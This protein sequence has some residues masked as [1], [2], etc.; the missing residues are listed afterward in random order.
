MKYLKLLTILTLLLP[1]FTYADFQVNLKYGAKG[2]EVRELQ[3]FL[4]SEGHL[5]GTATGNFYSLTLKAVKEF[6]RVNNLP[7]TGYFGSMSRAIANQILAIDADN[8]ELQELGSITAPV[9]TTLDKKIEDLN[10]KIEQQNAIIQEQKQTQ[11]QTNVILEQ[12]KSNTN[13]MPEPTIQKTETQKEVVKELSIY[14]YYVDSSN[15][16]YQYVPLTDGGTA[17]VQKT[18][19]TASIYLIVDYKVDGVRPKTFKSWKFSFTPDDM[20]VYGVAGKNTE[21][22][23]IKN[24]FKTNE[25]GDVSKNLDYSWTFSPRTPN[26]Y[27]L[28]FEVDGV[29]KEFKVNVTE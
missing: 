1:V 16:G 26:I 10:K 28:L 5:T 11:S 23:E 24:R 2:D 9:D 7:V 27:T 19:G 4:I 3:E 17:Y 12:I 8:T 21:V 15:G 14:A 6:Q 18:T 13:K 29:V 22:I 25:T 20:N